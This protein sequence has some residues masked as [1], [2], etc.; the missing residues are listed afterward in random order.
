MTNQKL[1]STAFDELQMTGKPSLHYASLETD[2]LLP[3]EFQ[4]EYIKL[5]FDEEVKVVM[6][7][8]N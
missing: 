6:N 2:D 1:L 4:I 3:T 5:N 8:L 7:Y